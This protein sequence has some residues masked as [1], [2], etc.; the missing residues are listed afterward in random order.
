MQLIHKLVLNI[1]SNFSQ[2]LD[3]FSPVHFLMF[4]QTK[5]PTQIKATQNTIQTVFLLDA[6]AISSIRYWVPRIVT[7][8]D[9][10]FTIMLKTRK[11]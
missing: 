8:G 10:E 9:S 11:A 3:I 6:S 2:I 7:K 1:L 5:F 4:A